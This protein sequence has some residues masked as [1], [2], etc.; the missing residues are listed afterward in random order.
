MSLTP[1]HPSSF[2]PTPFG[3]HQSLSQTAVSF[4]EFRV[5]DGEGDGLLRSDADDQLPA[6]G[7]GGVEEVALEH[8]VVLGVDRDDDGGI[9][10]SL[11]L[12][13]GDG[14]AQNQLV[15][16]GVR[17]VHVTPVVAHANRVVRAVDG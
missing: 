7:D 3:V 6:A 12:V 4:G 5:S 13:N 14:V 8:D 2:P 16:I 9:L 1:I 17:V 10:A 15:E 11:A